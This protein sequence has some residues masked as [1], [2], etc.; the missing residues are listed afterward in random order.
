IATILDLDQGRSPPRSYLPMGDFVGVFALLNPSTEHLS[1]FLSR[2]AL[3]L[4]NER[5]TLGDIAEM[6]G[7]RSIG[8]L[9]LFLA[10]PMAVPV[11][12]PG[13]SVIFGVPMSV[14]A[15]QL[16]LGRQRAWLPS[17]FA[18]RHLARAD[19]LK[20]LDRLLPALRRLER[21]VRP[22]AAW[23]AGDWAKVP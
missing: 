8:A 19:F 10:L 15:A 6:L 18:R 9:L 22:R 2:R 16:A 4:A 23:L 3:T 13:L 5:I 20:L 11:P 7:D 17:I 12:T 14:V 21:V 1:D